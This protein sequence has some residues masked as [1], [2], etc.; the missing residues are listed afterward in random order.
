MTIALGVDTLTY[1]CRLDAGEVTV[2]DVLAESAALGFAYVQLN[3]VHLR[4]RTPQQLAGLRRTADDLGLG[5]H[6]AGEQVGFAYKGESVAT[7]VER[8]KAWTDSA[9][10]LG[11][12]IVRVSSGFYR[13]NLPDAAAI[14]TEHKYV[15]DA[16][17]AGADGIAGSGVKLILENHSDFTANEYAQVIEAV[18][19]DRVGV[20]LDI[21]NPISTLDDPV[22]VIRRLLP[23]APSGHVKDYRFESMYV[24][25]GYH[26][27]GFQVHWCYPGEGVAPL[28]MLL[29]ELAAGLG[30]RPYFM[31]IEGLDS[32]RGVADQ[33][34]RLRAALAVLRELLP[35]GATAGARD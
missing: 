33:P 22:P 32:R 15:I 31:S 16:L 30:D 19:A 1:H 34:G 14:A 29:S 28:A 21:I 24:E 20:F 11:S 18:G 9:V 17:G 6:L 5:L 12:P 26:R 2:E 8:I 23:W 25:G 35:A 4:D 3:I 7:A 13:H 10:A 27:R